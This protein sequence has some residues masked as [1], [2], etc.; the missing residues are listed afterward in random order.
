[1]H[2]DLA[3]GIGLRTKNVSF[4][5]LP[6]DAEFLEQ[7][8]FENETVAGRSFVPELFFTM[9]VVYKFR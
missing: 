7:S 1:V 9:S 6:E 4:S 3:A 5:S 8:N 2:L